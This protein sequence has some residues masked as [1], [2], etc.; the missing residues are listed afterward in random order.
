MFTIVFIMFLELFT[1]PTIALIPHLAHFMAKTRKK[2][3][4]KWPFFARFG[5]FGDL[6]FWAHK[7]RLVWSQRTFSRNFL[8]QTKPFR[9]LE[10]PEK[11]GSKLSRQER[12]L[13]FEFLGILQSTGHGLAPAGPHN[14]PKTPN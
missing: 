6:C 2:V 9:V 7:S 11:I 5:P 4:A 14:R 13:N 8:A 10:K 3:F 12:F 1:H